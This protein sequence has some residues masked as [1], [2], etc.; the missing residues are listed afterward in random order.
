MRESTAVRSSGPVRGV[1]SE[2]VHV[3][4]Y[5]GHETHHVRLRAVDGA[6]HAIERS[7]R[8][9]PGTTESER[10]ALPLGEYDVEV[11]VDGLRR[12]AGH[13]RVDL[14][15]EHTVLVEIGNGLVSITEGVPR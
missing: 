13:C 14:R 2:A 5:D 6:G 12:W 1:G 15:P 10:D 3:R 11:E 9:A 4:N 7:Y 8:L